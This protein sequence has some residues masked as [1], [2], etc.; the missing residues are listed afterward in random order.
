MDGWV[1]LHRRFKEWE[2]YHEPH[3]VQLF[4][5]LLLSANHKDKNWRGISVKTGQVITGLGSLQKETGISIQSLRTCLKRLE[6]TGE[7]NRQTNSKLTVITIC[8]YETY[9]IVDEDANRQANKRATSKQ[10]DANNKQERKERKNKKENIK[11]KEYYRMEFEKATGPLRSSYFKFVA[12]IFN[13]GPGNEINEPAKHII[14]IPKQ[15][16]YDQYCKLMASAKKRGQNLFAMLDA[17]IN[18]PAY[19]KG[20]KSLYLTFNTWLNKHE[21]QGTNLSVQ[22]DKQP[23]IKNRIGAQ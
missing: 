14:S 19:V 16:T 3:M 18:K 8:K 22:T 4:I 12:R 11:E 7:I 21:I 17:M 9:Q 10:H 20:N 23:I 5:H 2:W 13:E 1:K 15:L 6:K